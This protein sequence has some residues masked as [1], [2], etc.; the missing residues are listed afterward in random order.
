MNVHKRVRLTPMARQEI[1]RL[2]NTGEWSVVALAERYLVSRPTI[3]KALQRGRKREFAPR[4]SSNHRYRSL[5]YG[6]KRLAKIEARLE[7]KLREKAR[8]YN[9]SYPGEMVHVDTKRLPML[10]GEDN[11]Q[12]R[13]YLFVAIDDYSRE[14][15]AEI[16]PDKTQHSAAS[17][18]EQVI[19]ECP[20]TIDCI[21][22]DNG[23]EYKGTPEH[24]F[25][26]LCH[27]QN[28]GQ[29]FTKP[30]TPQTNGK[31][32]RVIKTLMDMWHSQTQFVGRKHRRVALNRFVNYYNT[33]KPHKGIN[34]FTPYEL[35]EEFFYQQ[36]V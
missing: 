31:A 16:L 34:G 13:E 18:L 17:F 23:K 29:Y 3:Y 33:V 24:A 28:I 30:R 27:E 35:L 2:Y 36:N 10:S 11:T 15:Y 9:K 4:D 5:R 32:E 26:K 8:R 7:Q 19:H 6:I 12:S 25:A 22:S 1:W 21:Y 14:L 20:Y